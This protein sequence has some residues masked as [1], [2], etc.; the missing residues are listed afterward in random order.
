MRKILEFPSLVSENLIHVRFNMAK[1]TMHG[2]TGHKNLVVNG[3]VHAWCIKLKAVGAK[4]RQRSQFYSHIF[5]LSGG[6]GSKPLN[7]SCYDLG[8][9][10]EML[11]KTVFATENIIITIFAKILNIYYNK[12]WLKNLPL[13]LMLQFLT[14]FKLKK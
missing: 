1:Y 9:K 14:S 4:C 12:P 2:I 3:R 7:P 10:I 11:R 13:R 5:L 6:E 8:T